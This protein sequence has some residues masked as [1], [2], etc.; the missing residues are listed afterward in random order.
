VADEDAREKYGIPDG[1]GGKM[2]N[3]LW[4]A[5]QSQGERYSMIDTPVE[6]EALANNILFDVSF[7]KQF[8]QLGMCILKPFPSGFNF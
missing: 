2:H 7:V 1:S 4:Y 6:A 8:R 5:C 3:C